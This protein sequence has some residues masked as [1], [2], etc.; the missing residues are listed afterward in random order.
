M[1]DSVE[2]EI[3]YAILGI[4]TT[5][6]I[7]FVTNYFVIKSLRKFADT[8]ARSEPP[9]DDAEVATK[10]SSG[11]FVETFVFGL[12]LGRVKVRQEIT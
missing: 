4:L 1:S 6:D 8:K 10:N 12:L 2:G 3:S 7:C 11:G 5:L 9:E